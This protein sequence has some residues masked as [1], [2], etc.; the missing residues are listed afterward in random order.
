MKPKRE[1]SSNNAKTYM[2]TSSTWERR[3]LFRNES[4]AKLFIETLYHYRP[5]YLL[6]AFVVMP[7]HIHVL[8]TPQQSL[9]KAVQLIKGGFSYRAKKELGSHMEVWQKGFQDHRM[10]DENDY[11]IHVSYIHNNPVKERFCECLSEFPYSSAHSALELDPVPQGLKPE[12]GE[13]S[14]GAAKAAPFQDTIDLR[15]KGEPLV[16]PFQDT[17]NL[18]L[19]GEP[20]QSETMS[21]SDIVNRNKCSIQI[22]D[23]VQPRVK[24]KS[25]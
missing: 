25:A 4:W 20:I 2:V 7:D 19:K 6:H 21:Q 22:G 14:D 9:E 5:S 13:C 15:L 24:A 12:S 11:A 17:I 3:N 16:A 23:R 8:I 10:R 18:R 1:H